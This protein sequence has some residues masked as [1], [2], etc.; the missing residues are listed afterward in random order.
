MYKLFNNN[1][2]QLNIGDIQGTLFNSFNIDLSYNKGK[3]CIAP[4]TILT[5]DS[6][7]NMETPIAFKYFDGHWF[8]SA[9]R[10]LI[11]D[12]TPAGVFSLDGSTGVPTTTLSTDYADMEVFGNVLLV[13]TTDQLYSKASNSGVG[14]GAYTSRRTFGAGES[15]FHAL[16]VYNKRAY[17]VDTES[18]IFSF[19]TSFTSAV[20]TNTTYT[21]KCPNGEDITWMEAHANGLYIGTLNRTSATS[22]VYN[23]NGVVAD[24]FANRY[25]VPA[26]ATL[27]GVVDTNGS[28]YVVTSDAKILRLN[29]PGWSEAAR[30]P[31]LKNILYKANGLIL[32]DRFIHP[33]GIAMIDG[34]VNILINSRLNSSTAVTYQDNIHAGVWELDGESLYHKY[35]V[36]YRG[37]GAITDYGQMCISQAGAIAD[38]SDVYT[39]AD[40]AKGNLLIGASYFTDA[41]NV[42]YGIWVDSYYDTLPKAGFFQTVQIRADHFEEMWNNIT[43]LINPTTGNKFVVKYRTN[44][45]SSFDFDITFTSQKQFTTTQTGIVA[46]DEITIIQGKGS[47]RTAHVTSITGTSTFTV[48]LDETIETVN[49]TARAR[50]QKWKKISSYEKTRKFFSSLIGQSDTWIELKVA[51]VGTGEELTIDEMVL[52]NKKQQ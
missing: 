5:T 50:C 44:R 23:W 22:Y 4:S 34:R 24:V 46:G 26:K 8:A 2:R 1:I 20:T 27:A 7:S 30:F 31:I 43:L 36:S 19:D 16:C 3:L 6:L 47:G 42:G 38:T 18:Q 32:N 21:F 52:D 28:L 40:S 17:W 10:I 15:P 33:N 51:V 12:G 13:T 9:N 11:N 48:N 35:S 49:G 37:S 45:T 39:V 29:S 41:T 25:Q 14:N